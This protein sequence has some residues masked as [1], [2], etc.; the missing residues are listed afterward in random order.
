MPQY[1]YSP[2]NTDLGTI[3][4]LTAASTGAN[5]VQYVNAQDRGVQVRLYLTAVSGT[6]PTVTLTVEGYDAASGQYYDVAASSAISVAVD[7]MY[8]FTVYP[9]GSAGSGDFTGASA[10]LPATWRLSWAI[11]GTTPSLTGTI[12]G[13]TLV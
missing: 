5:S 2:V 9:G 10:N 8:T 1:P 12:G 4:T 11:G 7:T 3:A 6:S 13:C